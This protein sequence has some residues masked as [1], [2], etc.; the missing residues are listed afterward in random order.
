MARNKVTTKIPDATPIPV[1]DV[2]SLGS[3]MMGRLTGNAATQEAKLKLY[4]D[5]EEEDGFERL[6]VRDMGA[7]ET[8]CVRL[9]AFLDQMKSMGQH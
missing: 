4:L 9:R 5:D 3:E 8:L 7:L 2:F 6:A 1:D